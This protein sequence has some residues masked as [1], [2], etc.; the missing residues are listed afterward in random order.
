M[1]WRFFQSS[2][3]GLCRFQF[4]GKGGRYPD[5]GNRIDQ[6]ANLFVN[7]CK[8]FFGSMMACARATLLTLDQLLDGVLHL[9]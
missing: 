2:L 9:N 4:L 5:C 1:G 6:S 8:T 7:F 3:F